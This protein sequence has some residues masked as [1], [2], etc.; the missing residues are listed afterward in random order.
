MDGMSSD[1]REV[2]SKVLDQVRLRGKEQVFRRIHVV[3]YRERKAWSQLQK[4]IQLS[5]GLLNQNDM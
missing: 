2:D 1:S 4:A 5:R 3:P